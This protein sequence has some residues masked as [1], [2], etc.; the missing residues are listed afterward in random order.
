MDVTRSANETFVSNEHD[1]DDNYGSNK[2]LV[3]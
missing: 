1:V 3:E 2:K